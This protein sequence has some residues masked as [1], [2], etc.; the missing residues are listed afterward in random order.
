[1]TTSYKRMGQL[2]MKNHAWRLIIGA[3]LITMLAALVLVPHARAQGIIYG[4]EVPAGQTVENNVIL[5]GDRVTVNGN[6]DG[7]VIAVG[8]NITINGDIS[9]SLVTAGQSIVLNGNVNSSTYAVSLSMELG[10]AAVQGRDLYYIGGQLIMQPGSEISRD[11]Y[12]VTLGA[13]LGGSVGRNLQAII[14]PLDIF[15]AILRITQGKTLRDILPSGS[16]TNLPSTHLAIQP[17]PLAQL[18]GM[19]LI[20][21]R[22]PQ[23][24]VEDKFIQATVLESIIHPDASPSQQIDPQ[25]SRIDT[26][27]VLEWLLARL[28]AWVTLL[29]FG[30]LALLLFPRWFE[31][32]VLRVRSTPLA[33]TAWGLVVL[34]FGFSAAFLVALLILPIALFFFALT[35]TD[36]GVSWLAIGYFSL[37]LAFTIFLI[38]VMYISKAIVAYLVGAL[39]LG[40]LAPHSMHYRIFPLLLGTFLYILAIAIPILGWVLGIL[41]TL[42]GLGAVWMTIREQRIAT[43]DTPSIADPAPVE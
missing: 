26:Q 8:T 21:W 40:R 37:G 1:M 12:A 6:V 10:E 38:F 25:V 27:R 31:P 2:N 29:V 34:V 20:S 16:S 42:L 41:A 23:Y 11:L 22:Q 33:A 39:I 9:G 7:D 43:E 14:G 35:L 32:W 17:A 19:Q 3:L 30:G 15:S 18:G 28:R 4:D 5:V 13:T 24:S 36:L